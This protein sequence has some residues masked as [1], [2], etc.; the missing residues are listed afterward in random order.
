MAP[1][2]RRIGKS[3]HSL[4]Q[5]ALCELLIEARARAG[6]TQQQLAKKLGM[7]QSFIA[8]YEGGERR[9]DVLEFLAIAQAI[10]ADPIHLLKA[11]MRRSV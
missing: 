3:V 9:I 2:A 5:V 7:H 1:R 4:G 8:K 11:L 6:L 10:G